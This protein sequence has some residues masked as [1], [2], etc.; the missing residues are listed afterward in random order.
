MLETMIIILLVLWAL[1]LVTFSSMGGMVHILLAV[2]IV[3]ALI[4]VRQV[5][6][7]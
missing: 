4:R 5:R 2:A 7:V 6:A 1:G 3:A